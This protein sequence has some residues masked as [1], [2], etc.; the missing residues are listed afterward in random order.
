MNTIALFGAGGK[1]GIRI[2]DNL[3]KGPDE[4]LAV[5]IDAGLA[6][7][8]ARGVVATPRDEA[9]ARA[10]A[11]ILAVPDSLIGVITPSILDALRPGALLIIL[12]PAAAYAGEVPI[13]DDVTYF[14]VHPCHPPIFSEEPELEARKDYFGGVK[15]RQNLVCALMHGP[16]QE[17]EQGVAIA[18]RMFA[19]VMNVYRVTVEQMVILEPALTETTTATCLTIIREAMDEAVRCGVPADAARA[20]LLGHLNI[21]LAI[22]FGEVSSPFSDGALV[23]IEKAKSQLFQPDWKKVFEPHNIRASV[24]AIVHPS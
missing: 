23:A 5:E 1:M 6:A 9:L 14:I 19:P 15:A 13:R 4:V 17:Y 3:R 12:D 18:R 21:E 22:L 2:G 8:S 24:E 16:E 10:D 7:L 11:A 20:F